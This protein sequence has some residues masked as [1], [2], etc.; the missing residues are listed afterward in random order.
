M[1]KPY[2]STPECVLG[3]PEAQLKQMLPHIISLY[4][5]GRDI[6]NQELE[7]LDLEGLL[8][9]IVADCKTGNM[10][11][12]NAYHGVYVYDDAFDPY[13][14]S[15]EIGWDRDVM[16]GI[17]AESYNGSLYYRYVRVFESCT[18]TL[19]WLQENGMLTREMLE[20]LT[21]KYGGDYV[22]LP[23]PTGN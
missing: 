13:I 17:L 6:T 7:N 12:I 15:L 1:L 19:S 5:D 14:T 3:L 23:I 11:Q 8:D 16:D 22:T 20:E 2:F 18:N 10:N 21:V 4:T 9:A